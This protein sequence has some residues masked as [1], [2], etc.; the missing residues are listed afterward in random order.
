MDTKQL[1]IQRYREKKAKIE[2]KKW[3]LDNF[4][5]PP[6]DKALKVIKKYIRSEKDLDKIYDSIASI[7]NYLNKIKTSGV[8]PQ[9]F[10]RNLAVLVAII[11]ILGNLSSKEDTFQQLKNKNI[12]EESIS[13][14]SANYL[15]ST[16]LTKELIKELSNSKS[17]QD[18]N[19]TILDIKQESFLNGEKPLNVRFT[20][21]KEGHKDIYPWHLKKIKNNIKVYV[22]QDKIKRKL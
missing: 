19:Q 7:E 4:K 13:H 9:G 5:L 21:D 10:V 6:K 14:Y 15:G 3:I 18:M 17:I 11:S 8:F 1:S 20:L 16:Q 12:L 22:F 2:L